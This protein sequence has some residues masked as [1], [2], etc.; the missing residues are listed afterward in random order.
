MGVRHPIQHV[1]PDRPGGSGAGTTQ[2][3]LT[4][5]G[6]ERAAIKLEKEGTWVGYPAR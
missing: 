6:L 5:K 1:Y 3:R 2:G 4:G